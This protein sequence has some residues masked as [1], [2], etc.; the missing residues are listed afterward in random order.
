VVAELREVETELLDLQ[1]RLGA[2]E[3]VQRRTDVISPADGIVEDMQVHSTGA[4]IQ[5]GERLLDVLPGNEKLFIEARVNPA[6]INIVYAG[7]SAQV[8]LVALNQRVTHTVEGSVSWVSVDRLTDEATGE[9]FFSARSG[10]L[11]R[12]PCAN[13]RLVAPARPRAYIFPQNTVG[14]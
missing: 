9:A 2:A 5:P 8:R 1:E 12:A 6:D 14:A 11:S 13:S 10:N 4:V 7:M 3:D